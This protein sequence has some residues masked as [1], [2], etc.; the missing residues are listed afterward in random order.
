MVDSALASVTKNYS[1]LQSTWE[2]SLE[3]CKD[4]ETKA[5]IQGVPFQMQTFKFLFGNMLAEMVLRHTDNLS[6]ALQHQTISA[7]AG[8]EIAQM[9]VK[10]LQSLRNDDLFW[11]K[12]TL[13]ADSM[14]VDKPQLPRQHKRP[15]RYEEGSSAGS[16]HSTPK[17]YYRQHY[18]EA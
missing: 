4:T 10:T 7:A 3:V 8:Q 2:N 18:F 11:M 14:E 9:I 13:A 12:V 5:R 16:F 6:K 1:V 15:R 17:D